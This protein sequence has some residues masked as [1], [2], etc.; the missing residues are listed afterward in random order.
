MQPKSRLKLVPLTR[1]DLENREPEPPRLPVQSISFFAGSDDEHPIAP[2]P[3]PATLEHTPSVSVSGSSAPSLHEDSE[4]AMIQSSSHQNDNTFHPPP[5]HPPASAS[6]NSK[7]TSPRLRAQ[8]NKKEERDDSSSKGI[9]RFFGSKS[10]SVH[11]SASSSRRKSSVPPGLAKNRGVFLS[12]CRRNTEFVHTLA[13]ELKKRGVELWVDWK[14]IPPGSRWRD[15]IQKGIDDAENV[16][17]VLSPDWINSSECAIELQLA[18]EKHKRLVP[19]LH[20]MCDNVPPELASLNWIYMRPTDNFTV[21]VDKLMEALS[22]DEEYIRALTFLHQRTVQWDTG[23][24]IDG[25]LLKRGE[26][27]RIATTV[28]HGTAEGKEPLP[29]KLHMAFIARSKA[30]VKKSDAFRITTLV[31]LLVMAL[32]AAAIS[33]VFAINATRAQAA[34]ATLKEAALRTANIA[35]VRSLSSNANQLTNS[36]GQAAVLLAIQG[37][38]E[39]TSISDQSETFQRLDRTARSALKYAL[40]RIGGVTLYRADADFLTGVHVCS[41]ASDVV[42]VSSTGNVTRWRDPGALVGVASEVGG[43][44]KVDRRPEVVWSGLGSQFLVNYTVRSRD[45]G[46]YLALVTYAT[47]GDQYGLVLLDLVTGQVRINRTSPTN[48]YFTFTTNQSCVI[49]INGVI[50]Y[51]RVCSDLN[52]KAVLRT[53]T[54]SLNVPLVCE[55]GDV[56]VVPADLHLNYFRLSDSP[57]TLYQ[58][59]PIN[60]TSNLSFAREFSISPNCRNFAVWLSSSL[61]G[62]QSFAEIYAVV[63][64][65]AGSFI[66]QPNPVSQQGIVSMVFAPNTELLAAST[67]EGRVGLYNISAVRSVAVIGHFAYPT[68]TWAIPSAVV[69]SGFSLSGRVFGYGQD[70]SVYKWESGS[71]S[72]LQRSSLPVRLRRHRPPAQ[73]SSV[74]LSWDANGRFLASTFQDSIVGLWDMDEINPSSQELLPME[75]Y[76]PDISANSV[77]QFSKNGS[78]LGLTRNSKLY[79]WKTR[80]FNYSLQDPSLQFPLC[81]TSLQDSY[82]RFHPIYEEI[83]AAWCAGASIVHVINIE[84]K[85]DWTISTAGIQ[86]S[87]SVL[88]RPDGR[89]LVVGSTIFPYDFQIGLGV[90]VSNGLGPQQ[91]IITTSRFHPSGNMLITADTN[92]MVTVFDVR[93]MHSPVALLNVGPAV[94]SYRGYATTQMD[95]SSDWL[96]IPFTDGLRTWNIAGLILTEGAIFRFDDSQPTAVK[97]SPDGRHLVTDNDLSNTISVFGMGDSGLVP[98]RKS[99]DANSVGFNSEFAS[100]DST[101]SYLWL[102]ATDGGN[103]GFFLNQENFLDDPLSMF[104][105]PSIK[106]IIVDPH[107]Q[108]LAVF[109][110]KPSRLRIRLLVDSPNHACI[111]AGRSITS[112]EYEDTTGQ[113]LGS[114]VVAC[115]NL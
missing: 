50:E 114:N 103:V 17:F 30:R 59:V 78:F 73:L 4:N 113:P 48:I 90:S 23:G 10:S 82:L 15:E 58:S 115:N 46:R 66:A 89:W 33:V 67:I 43:K 108:Y 112:S 60:S 102:Q 39:A 9:K 104:G 47:R 31:V 86:G 53:A 68:S 109:A 5:G 69:I 27:G 77:L 96:V 44:K 37:V 106:A 91:A 28:M 13:D 51:Y 6:A 101:G 8:F 99:V 32:C 38:L 34:E 2:T 75:F 49:T 7:A 42:A 40:T 107:S 92:G 26:L 93:N 70:G 54:S 111:V 72:S 29:T 83:V 16:V 64:D 81:P 71:A 87:E 76:F 74:R 14:D 11:P 12:Y 52:L 36:N 98:L 41:D 3:E 97:F 79:I 1:E 110:D 94:Q 22:A 18:V 57:P 85:Q 105:L 56:V 25:L 55:G 45:D 61:P 84:T 63:D 21:G 95:L 80:L 24:R 35:R 65:G 62:V 100:F 88:W 20:Q 19:V